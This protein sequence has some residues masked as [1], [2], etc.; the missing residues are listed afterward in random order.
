MLPR[1]V[2]G[3]SSADLLRQAN[4]YK[5]KQREITS[6]MEKVRRQL[7]STTES[8]IQPLATVSVGNSSTIW[9]PMGP[10]P[11]VHDPVDTQNY[12][13][14]AG[15]VSAV[16][17]DQSDATGATVFVGGAYGGVWKS[18]NAT[19][20]PSS[21]TW[22]PILDDQATLA[23]GAIAVN[24]STILVGTG[25]AK[26]AVDSY[27]GLGILRST[28]GGSTWSLI[29]TADGGVTRMAGLGF[30]HVVFSKDNPSL[31]VATTVGTGL[32]VGLGALTGNFARGVFYSTDAGATWHS[33]TVNE[34]GFSFQP[35][36]NGLVYNATQHKFYV[37]MRYHGIYSSPDGATWTR[38]AS[39]P[40]GL[41]L[42]NCP[43]NVSFSCPFWRGEIA[44][45]PDKDEMY[46]WYANDSFTSQGVFKSTD[47]GGSWVALNMNSANT[48]DDTGTCASYQLFYNMTMAV[49]PNKVDS[50]TSATDVYIGSGN[51]FKCTINSANPAC[52]GSAEPYK[53]MD[54]THVYR[55]SCASVAKVHPDQHAI[56]YST[57]NPQVVY[58]GNDGGV[59]R[60]LNNGGINTQSCTGTLPFDN[61]NSNIGSL[62]QF[63]WATPDPSDAT[64]V[65]AGAQDNGTSATGATI[66]S[67]HG[68]SGQQ[69]FEM[70]SGDGGHTD[71][72]SDNN[73]W[74]Q[75]FTDA[76]INLCT[77]GQNC[78]FNAFAASTYIDNTSASGDNLGGDASA[79]YAPFM[80]DRQ[81]K[82]HFIVGTC[83]V[84]RG[85]SSTPFGG[86]AISYN[87]NNFLSQSTAACADQDS[88]GNSLPKISALA[89]G[90][91]VTGNGSQA[92]YAALDDGS[93]YRTLTAD[94]GVTSWANVTP[95][96]SLNWG[97]SAAGFAFSISS[98]AVDTTD[99]TGKTVYATVQGFGAN[100]VLLSSNGGSTWIG[101]GAPGQNGLPDAPANSIAIDPDDHTVIYV[102]TDVGV[103]VTS[104]A[105]ATW[106]EVGPTEPGGAT[107]GY[108]PNT[109]ITHIEFNKAGSTKQLV[110]S[111][112]GRGVWAAALQGNPPFGSLDSAVDSVTHTSSVN[113]ANT[114]VVTGWGADQLD[115]AP[116]GQIAI[117]IDGVFKKNAD[118]TGL[119]RPDVANAFGNPAYTN[120]GWMASIPANTLA[121]AQ[122]SVTV[123][124]TNSVGVSAILGP[125]TITVV[126][127]PP[128]GSLD[129]AVGA[130][131]GT[132]SVGQF[133]DLNVRGWAADQED[134]SPVSSVHIFFDG[135]DIGS[136]HLGEPRP[137]VGASDSR[138]LNSGWSF[139]YNVA[140]ATAGPHTVSA[141]ATDLAGVKTQLG[142]LGV[143]VVANH[144]PI[145]SL[146]SVAGV[147]SGTSSLAQNSDLFV[148]GWAADQE[149]GSPVAKVQVLIDGAVVANAATGG[150]RPDVAVADSRY[151][152]SGWSLTYNIGSLAVGAH[153]VTVVAFD[154]QGAKTQLGQAAITVSANHAPIGSLDQVTGLDGSPTVPQFTEVTARGWAADQDDGSP[155]YKVHV[156]I[157]GVEVGT[158]VLGGVRPDLFA[159][160]PRYLNSGWNFS[161]NIAGLSTGVHVLLAIAEDSLGG[162]SSLGQIG[163]SVVANHAPIGSLDSAVGVQSGTPTVGQFADLTMRGWAADQEDGAPVSKVVLQID[164]ASIG[165]AALGGVRTDLGAFDPRYLNS[166]W[167]LTYNIGSMSAGSHSITATAYD[168]K[169]ARTL[170]GTL[171]I[172]VVNHSPIGS[173]D[174]V[175]EAT[176]G[177]SVLTPTSQ[178]LA[179]GWAADPEDGAPVSKVQVL[180][181]GTV[182]GN[183]TLGG[184][185][186]DVAV[187]DPRYLNSGWSFTSQV[188]SLS[189]GQHTLTVIAFD[190]T[191]AQTNIGQ[192]GFS[193]VD[194]AP[195]GSLDSVL[196]VTTGTTTIPQ[197]STLRTTGWAADKEDGAP[198]SKVQISV[199]GVVAGNA[200]LGLARPDVAVA[201]PRYLNSGWSFD[202][203]IGSLSTGLHTIVAIAFDSKGTQTQ[204]GQLGFQVQANHPPIGS[205]D[206]AT[207]VQS[208]T[209]TLAQGTDLFVRGWA[210]D[211]EDGAPVSKVEISIDGS[212]VANASLGG[213][214]PD[215][216]AFDPR[217]LN[218]GWS[219]TY[220]IGSLSVGTHAVKAVGYDSAGA[221][222]ILGQLNITVN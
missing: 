104:N 45:R 93:I 134:G 169:G 197:L 105:G 26:S 112:Y 211:Q 87:L 181:D 81:S 12:G 103:F 194:Q 190:S 210:A 3:K 18:T 46:V 91:P 102:G 148:R 44:I 199:D 19:A 131:S 72:R 36:S 89:M 196:G 208:G 164:G 41:S 152:K 133:A 92:I 30:S 83:R 24:G 139:S 168:S 8:T 149:D 124:L 66:R 204:L 96:T 111:T 177:S 201:D 219:L 25:E 213:V 2:P 176:S 54:V 61:L 218:S 150:T 60:T 35:S 17:V 88:Q 153:T 37:A 109:V 56:D 32:S 63:I 140:G 11:I 14:L 38:L 5:F 59:Y 166:G 73:S 136:A 95:P 7:A 76:T 15:R 120:S 1:I 65:I 192:L 108:L 186:P 200:S 110:A 144:A 4:E 51:L 20:T 114:L 100:H 77:Q 50:D 22:T 215:L 184:A 10:K 90:G 84:W 206:Q 39:Q 145:G 179:R 97:T 175:G 191:G 27:Y 157:D 129:S 43:S 172:Q 205:L 58:F 34:G 198:V 180:I 160:D 94:S 174:S 33:V 9:N 142:N 31:V 74:Y 98:L 29:Q 170:L 47:G 119:S 127:A 182:I 165:N 16:A 161:Y 222:T 202:Y 130:Q 107:T 159:A 86:T 221:K 158:A 203:N 122:H 21:V 173:L 85:S 187:A 171:N 156:L 121:I 49:L 220:S 99:S 106:T 217:Y 116:V 62:T 67:S 118:V 155:V 48:C 216:G 64:G 178:L 71:I 214:R 57:S 128:F 188:G 52:G 207:G 42:T 132:A 40:G 185:R 154:S 78:G 6:A 151:L 123:K 75:S 23:V 195:F 117:Y 82:T 193:I 209:S 212:V 13:S 189:I 141:T 135:T 125:L 163:F 53:F 167:A 126:D 101:I 80:V 143:V 28:N 137:D 79:F 146:D 115:G 68:V 70:M 138:Y 69:F 183:A 55:S 162:R 113:F 147:R